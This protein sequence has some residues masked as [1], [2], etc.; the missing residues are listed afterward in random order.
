MGS[1]YLLYSGIA[2][3]ALVIGVGISILSV[4]LGYWMGR[5][6]QDLPMRSPNNPGKP[7]HANPVDE[8]EGDLFEEA[9]RGDDET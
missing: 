6:S 3:A 1:S 8:P 9:M 5:N 2:V 7:K 4:C